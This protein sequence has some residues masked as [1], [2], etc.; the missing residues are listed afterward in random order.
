MATTTEAKFVL[1]AKDR[2]KAAMR[3]FKSNLKS[4]GRSVTGIQAQIL[5]LAGIGG[6]GALV[7]SMVN[8][9]RRMQN[10]KASLETVTGSSEN[11]A[12]AFEKISRFAVTTPFDLDQWTEAFIKMK[13][14]GLD[15]SEEALT[16]YGNTASAM[17]KSLTQMIEAV[18]DA[19]TGEFERLKEF[20]I[21][22]SREGD[23]VT[24]TFRGVKTQIRNDADEIQKYL[25]NIG[26]TDFSG[27]ME[28]R[29]N[30]LDASFSNLGQ[31]FDMIAVKIGEAG[32][33]DLINEMALSLTEFANGFSDSDA[34]AMMKFFDDIGDGIGVIVEGFKAIAFLQGKDMLQM[35]ER[36]NPSI[37]TGNVNQRPDY[38]LGDFN[39]RQDFNRMQGFG[40][41]GERTE[42]Q[43]RETNEILR[44]IAERVKRPPLAVAG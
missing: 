28:K 23:R 36:N 14:L 26:A 7:T 43:M 25:Q 16:S 15:P 30:S 20:G 3:G 17:G 9:N 40:P 44:E 32:L 34:A 29:A 38:R 33:N 1:T 10:M 37:I 8:V 12:A 31:S 11:A 39:L 24:F 4:V 5:G 6:M 21:K 41:A 19:A 13:A 35:W 2:T 22:A 18:A 42:D 27:A